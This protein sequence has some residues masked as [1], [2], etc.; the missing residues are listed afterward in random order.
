M[1]RK[2]SPISV[3]MGPL[4]A[5]ASAFAQS[6]ACLP[7]ADGYSTSFRNFDL[8]K[9]K[10]KLMQLS[11]AGSETVTVPAGTFIAFRVEVTSAD[12]G[13]DKST[14]WVAKDSRKP[15]KVSTVMAS[16]GGATMTAELAP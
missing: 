15:V 1:N 10:V 5:D 7:L 9:Q 3:D 16:M 4:F 14:V 11:V 2:D 12:G 8:Q 13:P 6:V